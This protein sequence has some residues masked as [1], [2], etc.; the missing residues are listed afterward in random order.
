MENLKREVW[1]GWTPQD[2][3]DQLSPEIEM[4]MTGQSWR[5]PFKSR[6]EMIA[7]IVDNQPY[8]KKRI[9]EV[10]KYFI[11]LYKL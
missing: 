11:N 1:E 6:N 7:Y 8:Y 3:I 5:K 4:I 2:F 10:N 9:R